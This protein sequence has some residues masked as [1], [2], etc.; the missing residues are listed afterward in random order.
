MTRRKPRFLD[1]LREGFSF[2]DSSFVNRCDLNDQTKIQ[3]LEEKMNEIDS[4]DDFKHN[5][6]G[7]NK[8]SNKKTT[9]KNS[10]RY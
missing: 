5:F 9:L 1:K 7:I 2:I 6:E 3:Q 4:F 8:D 10:K